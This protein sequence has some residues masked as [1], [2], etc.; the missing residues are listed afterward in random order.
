MRTI[1]NMQVWQIIKCDILRFVYR[2][3]EGKSD[4]HTK[5]KEFEQDSTGN[6]TPQGWV[7]VLNN[8]RRNIVDLIAL[9]GWMTIL[10]HNDNI[11]SIPQH[12]HSLA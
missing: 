6:S 9:L 8:T 10:A 5:G 4:K 7:A 12:D 11:P 1:D 2:R 3:R